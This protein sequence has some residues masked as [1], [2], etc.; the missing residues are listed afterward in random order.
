MAS[1][2]SCP[3]VPSAWEIPDPFWW[4][5]TVTSWV[6]VP[7][8]PTTPI[9]PRRTTLAKPSGMPL[10]IEVPQSGPM[11]IRSTSRAY[12]LSA[13]S[14]SR[15]DVV[16]EDHHVQ[17]QPQRL[18]G[19]GGG[20]VAGHRDQREVQ[21]RVL[22]DGHLDAGGRRGRAGLLAP[23]TGCRGEQLVGQRQR[24]LAGLLGARDGDHEVVGPDVEGAQSGL[25]EVVDVGGRGHHHRRGFDARYRR[26]LRRHRHQGD[27]VL[28]EVGVEPRVG[29]HAV[30]FCSERTNP[31]ADNPLRRA[32]ARTW[33][34]G[35]ARNPRP[36]RR[37]RP[38]P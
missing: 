6:P 25:G 16:A 22:G 8:A 19:L 11:T 37:W 29:T 38:G 13:S 26:H 17:A 15:C 31:F 21:R 1:A 20:V 35:S 18:H 34:P 9:G 27:R 2:R 36:S 30:A 7:D 32:V 28:V 4:T 3:P 23:A 10:T 12:S 33:R 14:A 5:R 24:L